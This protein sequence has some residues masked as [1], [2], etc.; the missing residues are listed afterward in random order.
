MF[1]DTL[2][3]LACSHAY[4]TSHES[5]LMARFMVPT[6]DPSGADRTQVGPMLAPWPMLSG[7]QF[8][9]CSVLLWFITVYDVPH[10]FDRWCALF[11]CAYITD[12]YESTWVMHPYFSN[13][14]YYGN[15]TITLV[16]AKKTIIQCYYNIQASRKDMTLLNLRRC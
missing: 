4:N 5:S 8:T 10:E 3:T 7:I 1:W 12:L 6:W 11:L 16:P 15:S 13:H 9:L 14:L 2:Y